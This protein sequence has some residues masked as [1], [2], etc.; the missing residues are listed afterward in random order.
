MQASELLD[1]SMGDFADKVIGK[2]IKMANFH[3]IVFSIAGPR[4]AVNEAI[5]LMAQNIADCVGDGS[6]ERC[7]DPADS[8][9]RYKMTIDRRYPGAFAGKASS[10]R[11]LSSTATPSF[12]DNGE[13]CS[14]ALRY[15]CA[16][17]LNGNDLDVFLK[18]LAARL[19][20]SAHFS[21]CAVH[22]D[23][24]DDYDEITI[25]YG[26]DGELDKSDWCDAGRLLMECRE[27]R[28]AERKPPFDSAPKLDAFTDPD[29]LARKHAV[30]CW[31]DW[32]GRSVLREL[33]SAG[34]LPGDGE[35]DE[36]DEFDDDCHDDSEAARL[37]ED[38]DEVVI[39]YYLS[40]KKG[41]FD[42]EAY[43]W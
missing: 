4:A 29:E 39:G 10:E 15:A 21:A 34:V 20:S 5:L 32:G 19:S 27:C 22:A 31:T 1:F 36:F 18:A 30:S 25:D 33:V 12:A 11:Y 24:Y 7:E 40:G 37:F 42:P 43:E 3:D 8:Y 35:D 16:Y 2:E 26:R 9:K 14:F 28:T 17:G 38:W 23:E 6:V 41:P 13:V